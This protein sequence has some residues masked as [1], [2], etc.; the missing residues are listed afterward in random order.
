MDRLISICKN[1]DYILKVTYHKCIGWNIR[2]N[3][4]GYDIPTV[5]ITNEDKNIAFDKAYGIIASKEN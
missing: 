2:M 3:K 4:N 5:N 1:K